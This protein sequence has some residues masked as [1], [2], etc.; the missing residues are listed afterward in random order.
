MATCISEKKN[1]LWDQAYAIIYK[2]QGL[3]L[4]FLCGKIVL[5]LHKVFTTKRRNI[6]R[7]KTYGQ[8]IIYLLIHQNT[9]Y[10]IT[11]VLIICPIRE[12]EQGIKLYAS[13][14]QNICDYFIKKQKNKKTPTK[15]KTRLE[16]K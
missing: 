14:G 7:G 8:L 16:K 10:H 6:K 4:M 15:P 12:N 13:Q 11:F 2:G 1:S 9:Y 3:G 5:H